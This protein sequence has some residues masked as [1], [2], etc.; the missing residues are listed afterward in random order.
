MG[1]VETGEDKAG[2]EL[3]ANL[4]LQGMAEFKHVGAV[5][6]LALLSGE[7][8][9]IRI[10]QSMAHLENALIK[11]FKIKGEFNFVNEHYSS[12]NSRIEKL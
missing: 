10:G 5:Q 12:N 9:Q 8:V 2:F 1:F 4:I 6:L 7:I 11:Q 3:P